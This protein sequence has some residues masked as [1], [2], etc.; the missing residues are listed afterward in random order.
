[1]V[2][3]S[4]AILTETQKLL[5]GFRLLETT[6]SWFGV[7]TPS[8]AVVLSVIR[9]RQRR[10]AGS[11]RVDAAAN[12]DV[13]VVACDNG[14]KLIAQVHSHPGSYVGHSPGDDAGAPFLFDGLYSVVVPNYARDGLILF[15]R[16][17]IHLYRGRFYQ[18][19]PQEIGAHFQI[20]PHVLDFL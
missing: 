19:S 12:A 9:P 14:L 7:A 17:G 15:H 10:T 16:C 4:S 3:L 1:M 18:L 13:A 8:G 20:V 2:T 6:V 11:F 5:R